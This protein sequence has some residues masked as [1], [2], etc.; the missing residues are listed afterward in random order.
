MSD[1]L[2]ILSS[3]RFRA[4][5]LVNPIDN[6]KRYGLNPPEEKQGIPPRYKQKP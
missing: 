3:W 5:M 1:G 2:G 6:H 4:V